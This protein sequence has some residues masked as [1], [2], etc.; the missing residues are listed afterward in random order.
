MTIDGTLR[1]IKADLKER[2]PALL[3]AEG[4][5]D[6]GRYETGYPDSQDE[7]FCC[8]RLAALK[9]KESMEF[10]IHFALPG[11]SE[12]DSYKYMEAAR[13]YLDGWFEASAYGY[14]AAEW[15][16]QI[17]ETHFASGDIHALFSVTMERRLDDCC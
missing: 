8:V 17:F 2:L 6:F 11:A 16:L 3:A 5:P 4:A 10:V 9:G 12:P 14:D 13:K 1:G 7:T 15:E